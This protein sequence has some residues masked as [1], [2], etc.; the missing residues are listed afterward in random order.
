MT[1]INFFRKVKDKISK[2][3]LASVLPSNF[4]YFSH[5]GFCPC[6][7]HDVVFRSH[8]SWLRDN[9]LC[10]NCGSIPR[11]RFLIIVLEKYYPEWRTFHIHESSPGD[12]G[13]S[14]KLKK[15]CEHYVSSQ[16]YPNEKFGSNVCGHRNEDLENQT[17]DNEVF[18]IVI[19]QDVMEHVYNPEK[20]FK[21]ISRTLKKNGAHIF[22]V[23]LV[24]KFKSSEVWAT[25]GYDNRPFFQKTPEFHLNPVDSEGSPVTMHW[26]YDIVDFIKASSGMDTT[27]EYLNDLNFGI[28]AEFIE[29]LV[30]RKP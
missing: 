15:E 18:D 28:R 26:G 9:F 24:N 17:F 6:C 30:S 13:T 27:I 2:T 21:E 14:L 10:S 8:N 20:A 4:F 16:Y 5:K 3:A 25:K 29:V 11:E 23:P 19:T 7:E 1:I 22:T 12:R